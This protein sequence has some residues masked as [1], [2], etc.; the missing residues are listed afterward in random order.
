MQY[1]RRSGDRDGERLQKWW[2]K[3]GNEKYKRWYDV[4]EGFLYRDGRLACI[5]VDAGVKRSTRKQNALWVMAGR[6]N[7]SVSCLKLAMFEFSFFLLRFEYHPK[8]ISTKPSVYC[9]ISTYS[10][11]R[12]SEIE[13]CWKTW[14]GFFLTGS[15]VERVPF[16]SCRAICISCQYWRTY[17]IRLSD[18]NIPTWNGKNNLIRQTKHE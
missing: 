3:E 7:T 13:L 15:G 11:V 5:V 2:V 17:L 10:V 12:L 1:E 9:L 8:P 6:T 18:R 4:T 14:T 16:L